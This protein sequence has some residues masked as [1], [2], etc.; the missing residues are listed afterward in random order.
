MRKKTAVIVDDDANILRGLQRILYPLREE[1]NF[2]FLD[3][4][5]KALACL[6]SQIVDVLITDMRMPGISGFAVLSQAQKNFPE[7]VR[8]MLTGQPDRET[9][10]EVLGVSHYFLWKPAKREDLLSLLTTI[11]NLDSHLKSEELKKLLGGISSLPSLPSLYTQLTTLVQEDNFTNRQ[12]VDLIEEDLAIAAQVM[13]LVNSAYCS[14][15]RRLESLEEAVVYLGVD[16]LRQLV[17]AQHLFSSCQGSKDCLVHYERLWS[18]SQKTA[19]LSRGIAAFNGLSGRILD[20][21]YLC[22]LLHDMGKVILYTH[23]PEACREID[24]VYRQGKNWL[25]S[26]RSVLS[27]DHAMIGGYI[28]SLWGMPHTVT[29]TI[30]M[31]HAPESEIGAGL[32]PVTEAVWHANAIA[33]GNV[34]SSGRYQVVIDSLS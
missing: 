22:G 1:W 24:K 30:T 29:Q 12:V 18:H 7:T 13:K 14:L 31:H 3:S 9:L 21:A 6:S 2:T 20:C 26:E 5:E 34:S 25:E 10:S 33:Q 17:L 15:S 23:L 19:L 8:V 16:L 11:R 28:S 27:T 32:M 4:G